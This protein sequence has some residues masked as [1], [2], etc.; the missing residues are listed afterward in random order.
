M[1]GDLDLLIGKWTVWVKNWTWEYEFQ[2]D[3][4]VTWRDLGS[5]EK[6][7]G[8]WAANSKLVNV[9]WKGS[10]TRESWLRPLTAKNDHTWYESSYFRGK[11]RIEKAGSPIPVPPG[12]AP[13]PSPSPSPAPPAKGAKI[14]QTVGV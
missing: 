7:S 4:R 14:E 11:Y 1:A 13:G 12:P 6:G 5:A 2:R 10:P 8:N 3:G 9:W